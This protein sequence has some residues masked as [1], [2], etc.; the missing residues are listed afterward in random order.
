MEFE[1]QPEVIQRSL[2]FGARLK[3]KGSLAVLGGY[4]ANK[5]KLMQVE[6]LILA[7]CGSSHLASRYGA[8]LMKKMDTFTTV[9]ALI[10]SEI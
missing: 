2:N 7:A 10:A 3:E 9:K 8:Y 4:D 1:Q 6:H 5:Q